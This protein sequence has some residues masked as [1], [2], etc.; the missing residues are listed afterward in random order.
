MMLR[1]PIQPPDDMPQVN[2]PPIRVTLDEALVSGGTAL[3][4]RWEFNG[5]IWVDSGRT[6][7]VREIL[8]IAGEMPIGTVCKCDKM[9][10]A[11]W[12]VTAAACPGEA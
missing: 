7:T 3:A 11:G 1:D 6:E 8:G 9:G 12:C 5:S 4:S 10:A 2:P